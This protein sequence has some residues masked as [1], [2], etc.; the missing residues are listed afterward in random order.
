MKLN[1]MFDLK[2]KTCWKFINKA[3]VQWQF[4]YPHHWLSCEELELKCSGCSKTWSWPLHLIFFSNN[5]SFWS[6]HNSSLSLTLNL[7]R[8]VMTLQFWIWMRFELQW[9]LSAKNNL[10]HIFFIIKKSCTHK[11]TKRDFVKYACHYVK[12][13][14]KIV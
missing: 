10:K 2:M 6:S 13:Y 9:R 8:C 4:F 1:Q 12:L 3:I 7:G 5:I 11:E 14:S